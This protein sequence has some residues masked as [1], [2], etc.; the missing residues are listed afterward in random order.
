MAMTKYSTEYNINMV[1]LYM[2]TVNTESIKNLEE[3]SIILLNW[4]IPA[5]VEKCL[6]FA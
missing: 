6:V 4:L 5:M 3:I 2:I 1:S